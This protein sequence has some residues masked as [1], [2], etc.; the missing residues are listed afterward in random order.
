ML[1]L[2]WRVDYAIPGCHWRSETYHFCSKESALDCIKEH[3]E[4]CFYYDNYDDIDISVAQVREDGSE[5]IDVPI[6]VP[7]RDRVNLYAT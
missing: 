1:N 7:E 3:I 2:H 6:R 5:I 4:E